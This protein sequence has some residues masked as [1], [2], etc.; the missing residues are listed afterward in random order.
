MSKSD[1]IGKLLVSIPFFFALSAIIDYSITIWFAGTRENLIRNEFSPL[2]VYAVDN[3]LL[4]P[5]FLFTVLLYFSVSYLALKYLS[6]D[7]KLFY[8]ATAVLILIS[9]THALG[10]LSWYFRNEAYSDTILAI[11][12]AAIMMAIFLS[13][14]SILQKRYSG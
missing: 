4:A 7:T 14:W 8:A 6:N 11:A 12:G 1:R 13:G 3:D 9:L 5:Y 10:G 2:L